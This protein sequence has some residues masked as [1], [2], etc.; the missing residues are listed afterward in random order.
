MNGWQYLNTLQAAIEDNERQHKVMTSQ[1]NIS[2]AC[3]TTYD[4][5]L[6]LFVRE[7]SMW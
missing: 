6:F 1:H 3:D 2:A 5:A 7:Q 4:F